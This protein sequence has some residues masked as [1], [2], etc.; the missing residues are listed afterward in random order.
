[1]ILPSDVDGRLW[2]SVDLQIFLGPSH[3]VLA[4]ALG[5]TGADVE[6]K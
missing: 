5:L 4:L 3:T 1:M 6:I 2:A